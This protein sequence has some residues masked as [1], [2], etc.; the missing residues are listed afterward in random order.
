VV[1]I[2]SKEKSKEFFGTDLK[3]ADILPVH[4]IVRNSGSKE[5]EINH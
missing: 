2:D 1:P 5:F 4:L 3:A